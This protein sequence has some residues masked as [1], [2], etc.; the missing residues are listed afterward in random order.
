MTSGQKKEDKE[1][2]WGNTEVQ[3]SLQRK[4]LAKKMWD[5]QRDEERR[6]GYKERSCEVEKTKDKAYGELYESLDT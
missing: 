6:Q 3:E 1:I 2:W 5:S 4:R